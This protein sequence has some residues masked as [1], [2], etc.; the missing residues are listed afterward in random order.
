MFSSSTRLDDRLQAAQ[1]GAN[2]FVTKPSSGLDF[3]NVVNELRTRWPG[4]IGG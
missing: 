1:L 2:D 3:A 4:L